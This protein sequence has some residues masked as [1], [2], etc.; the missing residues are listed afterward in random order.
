MDHNE[1]RR[2]L[3]RLN[4]QDMTVR[5]LRQ[6]LFAMDGSLDVA[7]AL[8]RINVAHG[9]QAASTVPAGARFKVT[10]PRSV[11]NGDVATMLH[12]EAKTGLLAIVWDDYRNADG[13]VSRVSNLSPQVMVTVLD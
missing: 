11:W 2:L 4:S 7:D 10:D 9:A 12:M 5:D 13:S 1:L 8:D 6:A 3:T